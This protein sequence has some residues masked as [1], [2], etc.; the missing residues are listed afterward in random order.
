M[1]GPSADGSLAS[2]LKKARVSL[3]TGEFAIGCVCWVVRTLLR[4]SLQQKNEVTGCT[5]ARNNLGLQLRTRYSGDWH[6]PVKTQ[7]V[8]ACLQTKVQSTT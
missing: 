3:V 8:A 4:L 6:T 5:G 7:T 2:L 1:V